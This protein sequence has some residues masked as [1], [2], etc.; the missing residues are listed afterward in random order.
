MFLKTRFG[1]K[2]KLPTPEEETAIQAGIAADS[3]DL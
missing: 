2:V 3:D 1:R